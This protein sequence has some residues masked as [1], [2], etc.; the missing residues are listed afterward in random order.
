MYFLIGRMT[1]GGTYS[2]RGLYIG[3]EMYGRGPGVSLDGLSDWHR[4]VIGKADDLPHIVA[5]ELVHFQQTNRSATPNLLEQSLSEGSA[6]F[7]AEL[8]SGDHINAAAHAYGLEHECALWREFEP[9]MAGSDLSGWLYDAEKAQDHPAD[10]GYFI[11]YRIA[12]AYYGNATDT[13]VALRDIRGARPA[14][15]VLRDSGYAPCA[16]RP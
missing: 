14:L 6:D 9:R 10:L 3:T 5:H 12:A 1:S 15:E 8:V 16:S 4:A 7:I 2:G 13:R 11:G